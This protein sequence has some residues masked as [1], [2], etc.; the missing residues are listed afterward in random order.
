MRLPRGYVTLR[1]DLGAVL[2]ARRRDGYGKQQSV[3]EAVGVARETLSRIEAGRTMP[4]PDTLDRLL[5][6]LELE[7]DD[8]AVRG[9]GAGRARVFR[10]T[11][12]GEGCF[13]LGLAV[14]AGRRRLGLGLREAGIACG[15]SASQLSRLERGEVLSG[16]ALLAAPGQDDVASENRRMVLVHPFLRRLAAAGS[17]VD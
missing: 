16:R 8:V 11:F 14:R 5:A 3:A 9:D 10:D 15:F 12:R 1:P 13:R 17:G 6:V 2:R 7:W 4:R